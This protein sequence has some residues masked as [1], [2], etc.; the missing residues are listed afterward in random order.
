[1]VGTAARLLAF[2]LLLPFVVFP[3]VNILAAPLAIWCLVSAVRRI[4]RPRAGPHQA[5]D[6]A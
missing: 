3:V 2:G 4:W 5:P 6:H 1:M